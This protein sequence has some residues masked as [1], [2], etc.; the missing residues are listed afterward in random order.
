[1][2]PSIRIYAKVWLALMI[3]LAVTIFVAHFDLGAFSLPIALGIAIAKAV[4]ILLFF[5]HLRYGSREVLVFACAAY[6]WLLILIVGTLHDY[7]SR[8]W[9]PGPTPPDSITI[10]TSAKQK[11]NP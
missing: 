8:N 2:S 6:L 3:L 5:M 4:L 7:L 10:T 11:G 1:M 9:I